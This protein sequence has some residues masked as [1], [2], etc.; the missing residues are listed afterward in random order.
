MFNETLRRCED[1]EISIKALKKGMAL[2]SNKNVLVNQY[3]SNTK[4]KL[5]ANVV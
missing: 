4:D 3:Y 5:N 2:I 1:L